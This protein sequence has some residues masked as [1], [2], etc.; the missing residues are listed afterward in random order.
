MTG[1][2]VMLEFRA[3]AIASRSLRVEVDTP[4]GHTIE[5]EFDLRDLR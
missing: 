4:D 1:A 5:T 3:V 2:E